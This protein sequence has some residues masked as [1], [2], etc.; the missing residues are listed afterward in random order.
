MKTMVN[1]V[2]VAETKLRHNLGRNLGNLS[3]SMVGYRNDMK[4]K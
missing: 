3:H 4:G 2:V 1:I